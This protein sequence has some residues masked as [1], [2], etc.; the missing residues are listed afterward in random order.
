MNPFLTAIVTSI[1]ILDRSNF[2]KSLPATHGGI[3]YDYVNSKYEMNVSGEVMNEIWNRVIRE[4]SEKYRGYP[5]LFKIAAK[6]NKTILSLY[7]GEVV[8]E[9]LLKNK[10]IFNELKDGSN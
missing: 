10:Q 9:F 8:K 5:D 3:L 1:D 7:K 6:D 4:Y 2:A